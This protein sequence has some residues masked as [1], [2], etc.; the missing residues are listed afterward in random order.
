M[1]HKT[2]IFYLSSIIFTIVYGIEKLTTF[3]IQEDAMEMCIVNILSY[4]SQL[5]SD[6]AVIINDVVTNRL[7]QKIHDTLNVKL[8]MR[9]HNVSVSASPSTYIINVR[10]VLEFENLIDNLDRD[11]YR[12]PEALYIIKLKNINE[13][14]FRTMFKILWE[15]HIIHILAI[16]SNS[17]DDTDDASV[18]SYFP[19]GEGGCGRDYNNTIK[20]SECKHVREMDIITTLLKRDKPVLKNCTLQIG[21]RKN[22]P[23]SIPDQD[24]ID[25]YTVGIERLLLELLLQKENISWNYVFLP[26]DL[27]SG[28][29]F[30]NFTINGMLQKLYENEIDV[31][32]GGFIVNNKRSIFF[33][34][35]CTHLAFQ[36]NFITIVPN[37]GHVEKWKIIYVMFDLA[38]WLLLLLVIL[39]CAVILSDFC[40]L[41][42]IK[43]FIIN[44][45]ELFN[46]V[47]SA[48]QNKTLPTS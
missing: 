25:Q 23:L 33:D 24:A 17:N 4:R 36:D 35:L 20:I 34:V 14:D 11:W 3:E 19:Y 22:P 16:I 48:T 15:Y 7:I 27:E 29:V 47:G 26:E 12:K 9:D 32:F 8:Y 5:G 45:F 31:L 10:N 46:L 21:T 42:A 43:K 37:A 28:H 6:L 38:V 13:D 1:L 44:N 18:Y 2:A 39:L 41:S 40:N 30:D